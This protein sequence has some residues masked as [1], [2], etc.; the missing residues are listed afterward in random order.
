MNDALDL[1][2]IGIS[3]DPETRLEKHR[4]NGFETVLDIR[5]PMK[6]SH[7]KGLETAILK[8]L[9]QRNAIFANKSDYSSFDGW[10]ESWTRKS[11]DVNTILELLEM[12]YFDEAKVTTGSQTT[13]NE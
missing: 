9:H 6:G 2:Q 7:A 13:Q 8:S 10:T 5:G 11:I 12:V 3:N 1:L 4:K